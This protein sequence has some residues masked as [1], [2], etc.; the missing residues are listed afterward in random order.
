MSL[1]PMVGAVANRELVSLP[2]EIDPSQAPLMAFSVNWTIDV[3]VNE[4]GRPRV[5]PGTLPRMHVL[6]TGMS[7]TG[8]RRS[9]VSSGA[10]A[11][12]AD[13]AR[14]ALAFRPPLTRA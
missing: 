12:G 3:W 13:R 14:G 6:V 11:R 2:V 4:R 8:N 5:S 1:A 7:G 10:A 9:R